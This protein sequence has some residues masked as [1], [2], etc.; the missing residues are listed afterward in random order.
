[1]DRHIT[2]D[3]SKEM[4]IKS[5][6]PFYAR[7]NAKEICRCTAR[8]RR[9]KRINQRYPNLFENASALSENAF[10]HNENASALSENYASLLS[11]N[12][13][14]HNEN[15]SAFSRICARWI[16]AWPVMMAMGLLFCMLLTGCGGTGVSGN[17]FMFGK[18]KKEKIVGKDIRKEDISDFYYTVENIN[19][20]A[21]YQRYR[22]Y[23]EDGKYMFFHESRRRENRYGPTTEDDVTLTG[24]IELEP[25]QWDEFY[26]FVEDGIV[27]DREDAA[28][29]G[30]SGPWLYLYWQGDKS[31]FQ[32]FSFESY[33]KRES[34]E[35]FCVLL[36]E[37]TQGKAKAEKMN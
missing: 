32:E 35:E 17:M 3:V 37:G 10:E 36:A 18:A 15:A 21:F 7:E 12:V 22:F 5:A 31:R 27:R 16:G 6:F 1:M 9:R 33:G 2:S 14:E 25:D 11:E 30:G 19:F 26:G 24:T 13:F 29:S 20:N 8:F 23:T 34:F 28:D 4:V